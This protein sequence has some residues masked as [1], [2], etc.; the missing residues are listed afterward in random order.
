MNVPSFITLTNADQSM[1]DAP[2]L[3][4]K[5]DD[6]NKRDAGNFPTDTATKS[7]S[8]VRTLLASCTT[9]EPILRSDTPE[10]PVES[11]SKKKKKNKRRKLESG[12]ASSDNQHDSDNVTLVSVSCYN[13]I[14]TVLKEI[15]SLNHRYASLFEWVD[16]PLVEAMRKGHLLLLD[17][18]SLAEDAVLERLNSILEP[19]RKLVLAEKGGSNSKGY[20]NNEIC[21]H[22]DFRIFATMNPGGDFGKRELSPALRSR[23][24][25]IWVPAVTNKEDIDLVIES[26]LAFV[27]GT[28]QENSLSIHSMEIR[29][30][31]LDYVEWFNVSICKNPSLS[32]ADCTLSLRDVIAWAKFII[33]VCTKDTCAPLWMTYVHGAA[34]MHLDGLGI[35]TAGLSIEDAER[36]KQISKEYLRNQ[37]PEHFRNE[38]MKGFENELEFTEVSILDEKSVFGIHPF[39][40][41]LGPEPIPNNIQFN[42]SA[43]TTNMNLRRV[44]RGL[45]LSKP[46]LLEGS[47]G[48]GKTSLISALAKA[49]GHNLVR[50]NLSEQTDISDLMGTD[51]PIPE[52]ASNDAKGKTDSANKSLFR[53]CDGVFLQALK[54]GDWVL[55]DELNLATQ[56]VLEGLNS[57]LDHRAQ[58]YI[59]ELGT[60]INCPPTFRIFAAQNPLGQGG[61]RK[62]LPKSF[63]N[64]FTKVY[65]EALKSEDLQSIVINRYPSIQEDL[66]KK[67][68][69]FNS[70]VQNDIVDNREYGQLGSP[71]EFNLRDV[72]RWC[73]LM[74]AEGRTFSVEDAGEYVN[75]IYIQRLRTWNDREMLKMRYQEC[76]GTNLQTM[77]PF[78]DMTENFTQIGNVFLRR[79]S[80]GDYSVDAPIQGTDSDLIRSLFRPMESVG[81]C[82]NMNWPCLIVGNS[83]SGKSTVL[84]TLAQSSNMHL[85]EVAMTS[86]SDVSELIGCYEQIDT[87]ENEEHLVRIFK[88]LHEKALQILVDGNIDLKNICSLFR[89]LTC[90]LEE[91]EHKQSSCKSVFRDTSIGNVGKSLLLAFEDAIKAHEKFSEISKA[92]VILARN[93][94]K[95]IQSEDEGSSGLFRWV[96]GILVT[97]ME[98]G[99]WL[100]L[101]NVNFCPSSVLDRLNPLMEIGGELVLTECGIMSEDKKPRAILPHKNFRLFLSMNPKSGEVS[102]A[103]R[104]RCVEICLLSPSGSEIL[105]LESDP[106]S[107]IAAVTIQSFD[108]LEMLLNFGIRSASHA[109]NMIKCHMLECLNSEKHRDNFLSMRDLKAWSV[110][111][112][113]LIERGWSGLS[114][115]SSSFQ[116]LYGYSKYS[117][118]MINLL[119]SSLTTDQYGSMALNR[120]IDFGKVWLSDPRC[121]RVL[122]NGRLFSLVSNHSEDGISSD[123]LPFELTFLNTKMASESELSSKYDEF[124][125][126][127]SELLQ[128]RS[129]LQIYLLARFIGTS[130]YDDWF[131]RL[132]FIKQVYPKQAHSITYVMKFIRRAL[133]RFGMNNETLQIEGLQLKLVDQSFDFRD[134]VQLFNII[135]THAPS[136]FVGNAKTWITYVERRLNYIRSK[137]L[138]RLSHLL[139]EQMTYEKLRSYDC[140][141]IN[142]NQMS[143]IDLSYLFNNGSVD[144]SILN[145]LVTPSLFPFFEA[146]DDLLHNWELLFVDNIDTMSEDLSPIYAL[147][148]CRDRLWVCLSSSSY[149]S[150]SS[151]SIKFEEDRFLVQW[152]WIKK[153][154]FYVSNIFDNL[155]LKFE[156][157]LKRDLLDA[158]F[159][160]K[161]QVELLIINIDE[162]V[163]ETTGNTIY[164]DLLWKKGGHPLV[165]ARANDWISR[166][167][168]RNLADSCSFIDEE[169]VGLTSLLAGVC[170]QLNLDLLVRKSHSCLFID[171]NVK[172]D[173]LAALSTMQGAITDEVRLSGETSEDIPDKFSSS[174]IPKFLM[175]RMKEARE[176]FASSVKSATI[177]LEINT[178]E[179][180]YSVEELRKMQ[181]EHSDGN[182]NEL[183]G[184]NFVQYLLEKWSFIQSTQLAEI[185][186][187]SEE[188]GIIGELSGVL[189]ETRDSSDIAFKLRGVVPRIEKFIE[190]VATQ[191]LWSVTDLRPYQTF[192]WAVES[193]SISPENLK[194]LLKCVFPIMNFSADN[195]SWCNT[196]NSLD[197]ISNVLKSPSF[198]K[199]EDDGDTDQNSESDFVNRDIEDNNFQAL[200]F[201]PTRLKQPVRSAAILRLS[202]L[203]SCALGLTSQ[204]PHL[205]IENFEARKKQAKLITKQL[206]E[207]KMKDYRRYAPLKIKHLFVDVIES[208]NEYIAD[209]NELLS[210]LIGNTA[211]SQ[212]LERAKEIVKQCTYL[213]FQNLV[214]TVVLPLLNALARVDKQEKMGKEFLEEHVAQLWVFV[215]LLRLHLLLP[216]SPL[217]PGMRPAAKVSQWD[218]YLLD[219]GLKLTVL[220]LE[221]RANSGGDVPVANDALDILKEAERVSNKRLIQSKKTVNRP[222]EAASFAQLYREMHRFSKT[223][224]NPGTVIDIV[225]LMTNRKTSSEQTRVARAKEVNWQSSVS[226]FCNRLVKHYNHYEDITIPFINA[227]RNIQQGLREIGNICDREKY[228][229]KALDHVLNSQALLLNYPMGVIS[230]KKCMEVLL[231]SIDVETLIKR[232]LD[233]SGTNGGTGKSQIENFSKTCQI[234][235]L[236]AALTRMEMH[237]RTHWRSSDPDF[238]D[239]LSEMFSF[240]VESWMNNEEKR[241]ASGSNDENNP[242]TT[243]EQRLEKEYREQFPDH[244]KEFRDIVVAIEDQDDYQAEE[245]YS[246]SDDSSNTFELTMAQISLLCLVHREIFQNRG[247]KG[248]DDACRIRAFNMAYKASS[249]LMPFTQW[250]EA[251]G[252][253]HKTIGAHMMGLA[254]GTN[255]RRVQS[256]TRFLSDV[257]IGLNESNILD[258]HH[259]ANPEEAM[260]AESV[261]RRLL[262]RVAQLL[263]AFPGHPALLSVG[264]VAERL[265]RLDLRTVS[266]GKAL[267]GLEVIL[268]KAQEWEQHASQKV[269]LGEALRDVSKLVTQWRKLELSSW[270]SL[271]DVRQRNH[272]NRARQHWPRMYKLILGEFHKFCDASEEFSLNENVNPLVRQSPHWVWKGLEKVLGKKLQ[273]VSRKNISLCSE[274][275]KLLDGFLLSCSTGEFPERLELLGSFAFELTILCK[276]KNFIHPEQLMFARTLVSLFEH[277]SQFIPIITSHRDELREPIEKRL[278]DE[279][280]LARWDEQ[281]YYSLTESTEKSHFKLMRM[282]KEYDEVLEWR[283]NQILEKN[284]LYGVRSSSESESEKATS[285][286]PNNTI[287]P[288]LKDQSVDNATE[289]SNDLLKFYGKTWVEIQGNERLN[290]KY[291][292][293]MSKYF[294]KLTKVLNGQIFS[295]DSYAKS[296]AIEANYL[297]DAV[298]DRIAALREPKVTTPM[299]Q[300]ALVD[301]FKTLKKQ[302]YSNMK[303]SVSAEIQEA[304]FLLQLPVP[305]VNEFDTNLIDGEK[306]F[307]RSVVELSRL[308]SEIS[309]FG[310]EFMSQRETTL[311]LGFS[312][313]GLSML[314]QQRC[315]LSNLIDDIAKVDAIRNTFKEIGSDLLPAHQV[316]LVEQ[317]HRF[318]TQVKSALENLKQLLLLMKTS[319]SLLQGGSSSSYVRDLIA[320]LESSTE[321]MKTTY[322]SY[323]SEKNCSIVSNRRIHSLTETKQAIS[324][325]KDW[326]MTIKKTCEDNKALSG[327]IFS[328]C[329]AELELAHTY[330]HECIAGKLISHETNNTV[331]MP[332]L[333]KTVSLLVEGSLLAAQSMHKKAVLIDEKKQAD[334]MN[335]DT[336]ETVWHNHR[337]NAREWASINIDRFHTNMKQLVDQMKFL[338]EIENLPNDDKELCA[339]VS[340]NTSL[341]VGH[342]IDASKRRLEDFMLMYRSSSKLLYVLLRVFRV[343]V[344]KGFCVDN[345]EEQDG[346]GEGGDASGMNFEDDV[347]GTGMGEGE[348]KNDV[349]DQ[350]ENEEQLLGLKGDEDKNDEKKDDNK[351][352]DEEEA[353]TGMEMEGDFDGEM[354]DM[355]DKKENENENDEENE[356]EE[357]LDREMGD[358]TSPNDDVVDEKMWDD[359]DED[360]DSPQEEEK[361]EKDSKMKGEEGM[362]EEYRTKE[363][364][365]GNEN[366]PEPKEDEGKHADSNEPKKDKEEEEQEGKD[367]DDHEDHPLNEDL[368]D[369]YEDN[370][371]GVN[372][373][374]DE[375]G[376][377]A[378]AEEKD[379]GMDLDE[380]DLDDGEEGED[381]TK[382]NKED[383][384]DMDNEDSDSLEG[385]GG[386]MNQD[387]EED[388]Q[389]D[390]DESEA[391]TASA[392]AAGEVDPE[393]PEE[394]EEKEDEEKENEDNPQINVDN[395]DEQNNENAHGINAESGNDCVDR[396]EE[397]DEKKPEEEDDGNGMEKDEAEG[398]E[399]EEDEN[400]GKGAENDDGGEGEWKADEQTSE[401]NGSENKKKMMD[402][403][404]PFRD[405]GDV[406]K[407]WH[408]KLNMIQD[409]NDAGESNDETEQKPEND[410]EQENQNVANKTFE[411]TKQGQS[412]TTQMLGNALDE[413]DAAQLDQDMKD[414]NENEDVEMEDNEN[415]EDNDPDSTK[416]EE[417]TESR[418]KE[419]KEKGKSKQE[420]SSMDPNAKQEKDLDTESKPVDPNAENDDENKEDESDNASTDNEDAGE[421]GEG[422]EDADNKV[423]TDLAQLNVREDEDSSNKIVPVTDYGNNMMEVEHTTNVTSE[424]MIEARERWATLQAETNNMARR[425]CEKL[426]LVMEPL[427]ATK[428]RGD[429]RTGKR[430]NMKRV[431][432]FI[433]SGYRKDKI[434]LKRTKPSKRDY[435][436]LIAVD[437]S[438]SMLKSGAGDMALLTL[439]TMANGMSQ[440]EIGELG[441]A[442]FGEEMRLLHPFG[443]PFTSENGANLVSS[444][445]F[446]EKRTRTA[447]CVESAMAAL[448]HAGGESGSSMQLVFIISDGRI[449]RDSR[450][451]MRRLVRE[452]SERNILLVML[453]VEG[454][455]D[456]K[457]KK[458]SIVNMKE[459]SFENGKPKVKYFIE[460]YPFPYYIV[461]EEMSSLPEVMGDALRQ[462]FEMLSQI[463]N[464]GN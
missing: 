196:F 213:P 122:Q 149:C 343:L 58:V 76:F 130:S 278:K 238:I 38:T 251:H 100:H 161:R 426:R 279:V 227:V 78:F 147:L 444:F 430:I 461:L 411:F 253:E 454:N 348:G 136:K 324:D 306:Y 276:Q 274:L 185:C 405:P 379:D 363:D 107:D 369:N 121:A 141:K 140:D 168:L 176:R 179:N 56:S 115:L 174:S 77:R 244:G 399:G 113:I 218:K 31:M 48:V 28:R 71:W 418:S 390:V 366:E 5:V 458:D 409:D 2:N 287:F 314:C 228:N 83:S 112:S 128:L 459:V 386:E 53:W 190:A 132:N 429:Y 451:K 10:K 152:K 260:K 313:H 232:Q 270:P 307:K 46:I 368:E 352:L 93:L 19:T 271:L 311:M 292:V 373:R 151:S 420:K 308:R 450:T 361:F 425:L 222:K 381:D 74:V 372:V 118:N 21:A 344:A 413:D 397:E 20:E 9:T 441:I 442:S 6:S 62:G 18:M 259:D 220:K 443:Q 339:K 142:I 91:Y 139:R 258:F 123:N 263:T 398:A 303:W 89:D 210:I 73:D 322:S 203:S 305:T 199:K 39:Y 50:I 40:T 82:I 47:P 423:V 23:F 55:L 266:I 329:L 301:L 164:S 205:T 33:D 327:E 394:E 448:E 134:N 255:I 4:D 13:F 377:E 32:C 268:R 105:D 111:K 138:T 49:S 27:N 183:R 240:A 162:V 392:Q 384:E 42:M 217:D 25:E 396:T 262:N 291:L 304:R 385:T 187:L 284:F 61:G 159:K 108:A 462:W 414:D 14:K 431:I 45:Q 26:T 200:H 202:G 248:V 109:I 207:F 395:Q 317:V 355:P 380:L 410:S 333:L 180:Q 225:K 75:I 44:L 65:V 295:F 296:G 417:K 144:R 337:E 261:L 456:G 84:R 150:D 211:L 70:R 406:E 29:K 416:D 160:S 452:M 249:D 316:S 63:L 173:I 400:Q 242:D 137:Y 131:L 376:E 166:A 206:A 453:I 315:L 356:D 437:D 99:Y 383:A 464:Q 250:Y 412:S 360:D 439:A 163:F 338:S 17:E 350:I 309:V 201:G 300:R 294:N 57:C 239:T 143:P 224:S 440:L 64:R 189:L 135:N 435:R 178:V 212:Q 208:M 447:L 52:D 193:D 460:D 349:T 275:T 336:L 457:K 293:G 184:A 340:H 181:S 22:E 192:I 283:V 87:A 41:S 66:V 30:S 94:L 403:P 341:M 319:S 153:S 186:C 424:D 269:A 37:I 7:L 254:I 289:K 325:V 331:T 198:W 342:I 290:D 312:N 446:D 177:D 60:T 415:M 114:P 256:G 11:K 247:I 133:A 433:A 370:H 102:R 374:E 80:Q 154:L 175:T 402:A 96:D 407:F 302:G 393:N 68:I 375:E 371:V 95:S 103:M 223:I 197:I 401:G 334:D 129:L 124:S 204:S 119:Q 85:E 229:T 265:N 233:H 245:S 36:V 436:V 310:S 388:D 330:A 347:E 12:K 72:F 359:E 351:Q 434:W 101:E 191:T 246:G 69:E 79:N 335:E 148:S 421:E 195:H 146:I 298:F 230:K 318:E 236:F 51:L 281:T 81:R 241:L 389:D 106:E 169:K 277:Y 432:G 215:G 158:L 445:K 428:L 104:N 59:P 116:F 353:E 286:P 3:M 455:V 145:C 194:H 332:D 8:F 365:E 328:T 221:A 346:E 1:S 243:E 226:S 387:M 299:K 157:S 88:N 188:L 24:T 382:E 86:S 427:V 34:L 35:G 214:H 280:K 110:I 364:D 252:N 16:G 120:P 54:Q 408:K 326:L 117:T 98:K 267:A 272:V 167:N 273:T 97:A 125:L 15:E 155:N 234:S 345:S 235:L 288:Q 231:P 216:S 321:R 354:Y 320:M 422:E 156:N 362:T 126:D 182:D 170:M 92:N 90:E 463:Q 449:E 285:I 391:I 367:G 172:S 404:N 282:M 67:M 165:P 438:E 219:L 209:G 419:Q 127:S 297:C 358:D 378:D 323:L 357:E 43:P 171:T 257:S 264:Q 237:I